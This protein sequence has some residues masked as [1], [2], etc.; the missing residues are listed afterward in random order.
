MQTAVR[1]FKKM[2]LTMI[3]GRLLLK[4]RSMNAAIFNLYSQTT[5]NRDCRLKRSIAASSL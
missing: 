1:T 4:R 3:I 5:F 2:R